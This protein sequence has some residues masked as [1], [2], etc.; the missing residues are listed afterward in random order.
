M[1][2]FASFRAPQRTIATEL[3][4]RTH[5]VTH[6]PPDVPRRAP[7][8][9]FR[10][11]DSLVGTD[12]RI[13]RARRTLATIGPRPALLVQYV[14]HSA[15]SHVSQRIL[16]RTYR[17]RVTRTRGAPTVSPWPFRLPPIDDLPAELRQA[18]HVIRR[19]AD[20]AFDHRFDIL[21]SGPV[22][23]GTPINWHRDFKSGFT[24]PML[25]YQDVPVTRLSDNS[26]AKVPWELSRCHHILA[27]ARAACLFQE[28]CY[29]AEAHQQ[30]A[31]WIAANPPGI[32]INW[33]NTMEV[34]LRAT[35]LVWILGTL[36]PWPGDGDTNRRAIAS[37]Q[38]HGHHIAANLEGSPYLRSNHYLADMLG[39]LS[40]GYAFRAHRKGQRWLR[41][42]HR[43]FEREMRLQV[44]DDGVDFEASTAYHG[45]VMEMFIIA[46]WL[47]RAAG[48]PLS[49]GYDARLTRMLRFS[50]S[51]RLDNGH[52]PLFGDN[53]SGRVL[54]SDSTREPTHDNLLDL[55]AAAL[56]SSRLLPCPPHAEV[57]WNFGVD[58]WSRISRAPKIQRSVAHSLSTRWLLR[59]R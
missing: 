14:V 50:R 4:R 36:G 18:A 55:G 3:S 8:F 31:D 6:R 43:A 35:N 48:Y 29:A 19:Q 15:S 42:A 33:T 38:A 57:A 21:G 41:R 10:P 9:P 16:R 56:G 2:C 26:D 20:D 53:D 7:Y 54:P 49:P 44:F 17:R 47:A 13:A 59:S 27:L 37:L 45:L 23:L 12:R 24:W 46:R 34:A 25:F 32:G 1:R 52:V 28:P 58:A 11:R 40:L 51:I 22:A 39:L 30:L 5:F